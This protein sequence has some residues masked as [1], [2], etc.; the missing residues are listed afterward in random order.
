MGTHSY[1]LMDR[2]FVGST[3]VYS[4]L[5][6]RFPVLIIPSDTQY[7]PV[8]KIA[9]ASNLKSIYEM[10]T[11][12]IEFIVKTFDAELEIFYVGKDEKDINKHT[13]ESLLLDHRLLT[14]D[15][16]FYFID[17][18]D[19][20]KGITALA[21]QHDVDL[22]LVIPRKH[23]LFHRSQSKD[24]IFYTSIPMMAVHEND[25]AAQA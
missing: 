15:P 12:E 13:V 24:F 3:T 21:R 18:E 22:L 23:G 4:A 9:L 6:L 8:K 7:R 25:V 10:P 20:L 19:I 11:H 17:D 5:H 2:F 16:Q 14:L 1:S